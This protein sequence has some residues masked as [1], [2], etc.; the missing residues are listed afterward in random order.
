[1]ATTIGLYFDGPAG[2]LT[3]FKDGE[4]LGVAFTGKIKII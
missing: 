2:T 4:D 1:V 3:Y